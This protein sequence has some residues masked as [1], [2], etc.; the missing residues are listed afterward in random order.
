MNIGDKITND[1]FHDLPDGSEVVAVGSGTRYVKS[2]GNMEGIGNHNVIAFRNFMGQ[3]EVVWMPGMKGANAGYTVAQTINQQDLSR[4]PIGTKWR[5][6]GDGHTRTIN[7]E[8]HYSVDG[9]DG[10]Y[11]IGNWG[12]GSGTIT[13]LPER[14]AVDTLGFA[15]GQTITQEDLP[16]LPVGTTFRQVGRHTDYLTVEGGDDRRGM[17]G[18]GRITHYVEPGQGIVNGGG[19]LPLTQLLGGGR[20]FII[21]DLPDAKP[22]TLAEFKARVWRVTR[23]YRD[24]GY[25]GP[26]A[27]RMLKILGITE[28]EVVDEAAAVQEF[29]D[30]MWNTIAG[31]A[32]NAGWCA[33]WKKPL[34]ELGIS[35]PKPKTMDA[36]VTITIDTLRTNMETLMAALAKVEGVNAVNHREQPVDE[37]F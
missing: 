2:V 23:P 27:K 26:H 3:A 25:T 7:K 1:R 14:K 33:T 17:G 21:T 9:E 28:P 16:N 6:H 10:D 37:P 22:E 32:K 34:A 15:I 31:E 24:S 4:L 5:S 18:N 30:L 19:L 35:E 8:G 11:P 12:G 20:E 36:D 13:H 29:K